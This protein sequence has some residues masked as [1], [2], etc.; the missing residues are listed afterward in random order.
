MIKD[1]KNEYKI[2]VA[3]PGKQHS[4]RLA[5]ALKKNNML[6]KYVT[7]VYDRENS[8][9]MKLIKKITSEENKNRVISRKNKDLADKDV[10]QYG[11][12]RG[13]IEIFLARF[14]RKRNL[15]NWWQK[16]TTDFFGKKV[17]KLAIKNNVDAVIMY[18]TNAKKCF[19][20]LEKKA[21]NILRIMDVSAANRLYMKKIYE[22]DIKTCSTF[23]NKLK[24]ERKFLWNIKDCNRLKKELEKTNIF[25]VP[26]NFVKKS[27]LYSG[28]NEMQ[29]KVCPYGSNFKSVDKKYIVNKN[30]PLKAV[31]VGNVTEMKGIYYLLEAMLRLSS[32]D[33]NLTVIGNFDNNSRIFDKY[34]KKIKFLGRV[35]HEKIKDI[36]LNS[37]LFVFPSLGEGLSLAVLEAMAC[38]LPCIVSENSGAN[39]A[40]IDKVNG[41]VI[42]IQ[43]IEEIKQKI[44]W[45]IRNREQIP[46]MGKKA[47]EIARN[48]TWENYEKNIDKVFK[49][50]FNKK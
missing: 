22:D 42:K 15:Y 10:V 18:D 34:M 43:D 31:Y 8:L 20:I 29:I 36:L 17:A 13:L 40:I 35:P 16:R 6:F 50:I 37:D 32:N 24:K 30:A 14:D 26:S 44:R 19:E 11:E 25:L 27:L 3:H 46:L 49:E 47:S 33:V 48:Y 21:P 5:S 38:G 2:I 9:L 1:K 23:A 4:F 12:I 45:F 28:I 39:D 41:F 7:T